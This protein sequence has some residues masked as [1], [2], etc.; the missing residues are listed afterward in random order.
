MGRVPGGASLAARAL[1]CPSRPRRDRNA[2]CAQG[3]PL[4]FFSGFLLI[5]YLLCMP[6]S[7]FPSTL[8][9]GL[10]RGWR[11][12]FINYWPTL[13]KNDK[14]KVKRASKL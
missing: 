4:V 13:L 6:E 3:P 7:S 2:S 12:N 9:R 10:W 1:S 11:Q 5:R 14:G 8:C